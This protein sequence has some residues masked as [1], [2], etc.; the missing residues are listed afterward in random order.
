MND[1]EPRAR[2]REREEGEQVTEDIDHDDDAH[3]PSVARQRANLMRSRYDAAVGTIFENDSAVGSALRTHLS[4]RA[5][6]PLRTTDAASSALAT[7][8]PSK[9]DAADRASPF[10]LAP[11]DDLTATLEKSVRASIA[12][13]SA[14][15]PGLRLRLTPSVTGALVKSS[16]GKPGRLPLGYLVGRLNDIP[17][18][19]LDPVATCLIEQEADERIAALDAPADAQPAGDPPHTPPADVAG[20]GST[21]TQPVDAVARTVE[22]LLDGIGPRTAGDVDVSPR[23]DAAAV[24]AGIDSFALRAGP[25]D[26]TAY[27]DFVKL[28]L[29]LE[30]VW[31]EVLDDT[32]GAHAKQLYEETVKL[33]AFLGDTSRT[34]PI[35]TV[36]D[37][38]R[39]MGEVRE[40]ADIAL[41]VTPSEIRP[42]SLGTA[43]EPAQGTTVEAVLGNV[44]KA[45]LDPA[46]AVA[47]AV[48]GDTLR[49]IVDPLGWTVGA[50]AKVFAGK[51]Q[52]T[53]SSFPGPLP[54]EGD[55]ISVRFEAGAAPTGTVQIVITNRPQASWWK[56]IQFFEYGP[57]GAIR[58]NLRISNDP[59]Y[60]EAWKRSSYNR[61]ELAVT[62]LPNGVLE[63]QKAA[64]AGVHTGFY[65]LND[66]PARLTDGTRA[67]FTWEKD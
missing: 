58:T 27:Y 41:D 61:L 8:S 9:R 33:K 11:N 12:D 34:R 30:D 26:V 23:A 25:A 6:E 15:S 22:K 4:N 54:G 52:L 5:A 42:P 63:F 47:Q 49:A 50:L 45:A 44:V 56:G 14:T 53:W 17:R 57:G 18:P 31:T 64:L 13:R 46:G 38:T 37:L 66:L 16:G 19:P 55:T 35:S 62:Q 32:L 28:S 43:D 2:S 39:L 24:Q 20:S 48:G 65:V 10:Y 40:L 21:A 60:P 1:G 7:F 36:T 29:A 67:T 3:R 51:S 59:A